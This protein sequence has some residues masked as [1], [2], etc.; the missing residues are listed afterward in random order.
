LDTDVSEEYSA[1]CLGF[2]SLTVLN[3]RLLSTGML[4][5]VKRQFIDVSEELDVSIFRVEE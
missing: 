4:N 3:R 1:A 2:E 5:R